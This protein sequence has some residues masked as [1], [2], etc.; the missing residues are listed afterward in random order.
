MCMIQRKKDIDDERER[1][2]K[3]KWLIKTVMNVVLNQ[4]FP[5]RS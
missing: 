1:E 3:K 2:R 5:N 4:T